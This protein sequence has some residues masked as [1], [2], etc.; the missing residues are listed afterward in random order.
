MSGWK[1]PSI[2][3]GG[4]GGSAVSDST[5]NGSIVVNGTEIVVFDDTPLKS[6]IETRLEQVSNNIIT[7]ITGGG[8]LVASE[9]EF[10]GTT[11]ITKSYTTDQKGF[12][13]T[14]DGTPN[15]DPSL[16]FTINGLTYTVKAGESYSGGF[17]AF[18]QVD[19]VTTTPFRAHALIYVVV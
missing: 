11:N 6:L 17:S 12:S 13:I 4:G 8:L 3:S 10:T 15:V 18:R 16:S 9:S 14:N 7:S 1:K 19:I 5:T 2:I